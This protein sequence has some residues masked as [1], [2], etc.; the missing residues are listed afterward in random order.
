MDFLPLNS[1]EYYYPRNEENLA[2]WLP[3]FAKLG[4]LYR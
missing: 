3:I 2:G 1:R 4:Q